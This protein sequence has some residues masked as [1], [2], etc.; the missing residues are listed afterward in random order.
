MASKAGAASRPE[1]VVAL[2]E[3]ENG[4]S[5]RAFADDQGAL[6]WRRAIA[7]RWWDHDFA[8]ERPRTGD[9]GA[10]YFES[11]EGEYFR[12]Y[13]VPVEGWRSGESRVV[14]GER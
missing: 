6:A 9:I 12:W 4:T 13:R 2:Y 3:H 8:D 7:K 1:V 10:A 14:R 5:V 11:I